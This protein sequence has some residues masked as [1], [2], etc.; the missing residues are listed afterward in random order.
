MILGCAICQD[1][2]SEAPAAKGFTEYPLPLGMSAIL[3]FSTSL[4][5]I[6][7]PDVNSM[8]FVKLIGKKKEIK[9]LLR[10]FDRLH[11]LKHQQL[12]LKA[13]K[14]QIR[15]LYD[16]YKAIKKRI[17][18]LEV[19]GS[20]DDGNWVVVVA[21][22][23]SWIPD[24]RRFEPNRAYDVVAEVNDLAELF[25]AKRSLQST[26]STYERDFHMTNGRQVSSFA[27][28]KPIAPQY[29]KY[30]TI[31]KMIAILTDSR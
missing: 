18:V 22:G 12:P 28:M 17:A 5:D 23:S 6:P 19:G 21:G 9:T 27:D 16:Y 4:M 13:D 14:E 2:T 26:L 31:K 10:E 20:R 25:A 15:G 8:S 1:D 3:A 7:R 29:E 11:L 30:K 24:T